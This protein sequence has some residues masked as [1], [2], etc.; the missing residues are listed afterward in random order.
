MRC[1]AGDGERVWRPILRETCAAL[2]GVSGSKT[3]GDGGAEYALSFPCQTMEELARCTVTCG[4][5]AVGR[6]ISPGSEII[7]GELYK[8]SQNG[9]S[10]KRRA[11]NLGLVEKVEASLPPH[12][13]TKWSSFPPPLARSGCPTGCLS[14][15][16]FPPSV[17][18]QLRPQPPKRCP[19]L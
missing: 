2:R 15:A 4:M 8:H 3:G 11:G 6:Q 10:D 9:C 12:L 5:R 17:P 16:R 1:R 19:S 14:G 18:S 7:I 13:H